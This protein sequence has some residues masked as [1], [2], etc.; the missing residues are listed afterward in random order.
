MCYSSG[1]VGGHAVSGV[2]LS[3]GDLLLSND[4]GEGTGS[5]SATLNALQNNKLPIFCDTTTVAEKTSQFIFVAQMVIRHNPQLS[6]ASKASF[7]I[8]KQTGGDSF[9]YG[10]LL[11]K[12]RVAYNQI[13]RTIGH[14]CQSVLRDKL[15]LSMGVG[16]ACLMVYLC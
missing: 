8:F 3:D 5:V 13:K 6:A 11:M 14:I 9:S 15:R 1:C 7:R 16:E 10:M 12:G 4:A 2:L